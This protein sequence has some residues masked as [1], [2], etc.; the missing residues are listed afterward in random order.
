MYSLSRYEYLP[1]HEIANNGRAVSR[2][3]SIQDPHI[4][5]CWPCLLIHH[6]YNRPCLNANIQAKPIKA[7]SVDTD[8]MHRLEPH[9]REIHRCQWYTHNA[10][11]MLA[12]IE[13]KVSRISRVRT[14]MTR[15]LDADRQAQAS[16]GTSP[17][18]T[19]PPLTFRLV[20]SLAHLRAI[21]DAVN[22]I[23][24]CFKRSQLRVSYL[25]RISC[26]HTS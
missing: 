3:R 15:Y 19:P 11:A 25:S 7:S 8:P 9:E 5:G 20:Y 26:L 16:F 6:R 1:L 14:I 23:S 2:V 17:I 12:T 4:V 10:F 13:K 21:M 24:A 18:A 22:N